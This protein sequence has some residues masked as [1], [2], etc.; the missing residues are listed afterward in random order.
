MT[1]NPPNWQYIPLLHLLY[2]AF[3]GV[4]CYQAYL[5]GEPKT[6]IDLGGDANPGVNEALLHHGPFGG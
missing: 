2:I 4:I 1:Y 3:W 6:T 5:L